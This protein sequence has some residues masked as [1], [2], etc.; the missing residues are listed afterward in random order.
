MRFCPKLLV[1]LDIGAELQEL[2][3]NSLELQR[4]AHRD[5]T[6]EQSHALEGTAHA[7]T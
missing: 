3:F 7:Q 2:F 5:V 6:R 1:L 4:Q